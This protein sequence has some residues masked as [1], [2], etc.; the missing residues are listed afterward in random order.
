MIR[1]SLKYVFEI[2]Y[3]MINMIDNLNEENLY[4]NYLYMPGNKFTLTKKFETRL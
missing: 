3:I 1:Q 4:K 2:S